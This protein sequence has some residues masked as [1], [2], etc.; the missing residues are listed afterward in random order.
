MNSS[1]NADPGMSALQEQVA[2]LVGKVAALRDEDRK[3]HEANPTLAA[4]DKEQAILIQALQ[5]QVAQLRAQ[6][7]KSRCGR[8]KR[9]W[10]SPPNTE[11]KAPEP[12][13]AVSP[14]VQDNPNSAAVNQDDG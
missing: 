5:T 10:T 3:V 9:R 2:T 11:A 4:R 12:I 13:S 6:M 1:F 14:S 7:S 8:G